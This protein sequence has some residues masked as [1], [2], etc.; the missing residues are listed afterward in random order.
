MQSQ[1]SHNGQIR[2]SGTGGKPN[3]A[4]PNRYY[5][6]PDHLGSTSYITDA[7]GEVYQHLEYFAFGET[8]VEE[9]SNTNRTPY[10]YNGKELDALPSVVKRRREETGLYYYG[11]R[12]YDPVTSIFVSVDPLAEKY[13]FQSG[14]VYAANNPVRYVDVN[15]EGPGDPFDD[16][17]DAARDFAKTYNQSSIQSGRE[18]GSQIYSYKDKNGDKKYSY[19]KPRVGT[20]HVRPSR[21]PLGKRIEATIHSHGA[22]MVELEGKFNFRMDGS[23]TGNHGFS[24]GQNAK[25]GDIPYFRRKGLQKSYVVLSTGIV[26]KWEEDGDASGR[27]VVTKLDPKGYDIAVDELYTDWLKTKE[28]EGNKPSQ[29]TID[30]HKGKREERARNFREE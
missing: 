20:D 1:T 18:Y 28:K 17:D 16:P 24:I 13:G 10:L 3:P 29:M 4:E 23:N 12:Y 19:S 7:T 11:A 26:K 9:H 2:G 6:H 5:Y 14:Y 15:G 30:R 8:F 22:F 27:G 21:R 25:K